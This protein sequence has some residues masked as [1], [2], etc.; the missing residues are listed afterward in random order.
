MSE[1][2]TL[3]V[4]DPLDRIHVEGDSTFI[5]MVEA[6]RRGW[7]VWMCTPDDL[8]VKDGLAH[9]RATRVVASLDTP[10][11][12]AETPADLSLGEVDVVWM[13]K[14]PPFDIEYIF[15]TYVP[16]W[17][18]LRRLCST[19]PAPSATRTRNSSRCSSRSTVHPRC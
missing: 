17:F 2:R 18:R 8:Y 13:R 15:A 14:D 12:V 5:L 19:T 4:M 7:P 1:L 3:F 6:E 9:A 11:F 16:T 10:H